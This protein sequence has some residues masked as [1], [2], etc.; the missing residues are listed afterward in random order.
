MQNYMFET[1]RQSE[2]NYPYI[3]SYCSD[4]DNIPMHF[5]EELEIVYILEG[6]VDVLCD[7]NSYIGKPGDLFVFMPGEVHTL[8]GHTNHTTHIF[9]IQPLSRTEKIDFSQV[10]LPDNL[11]STSH[12]AYIPLTE[13][14]MQM[15][16]EDTQKLPGYE[17]AVNQQI[18]AFAMH[19]LRLC[20]LRTI[21]TDEQTRL[22][23]K[24]SFITNA[25]AYIEQHYHEKLD[26]ETAALACGY[27]KYYFAHYF[28]E[29]LHLSF[30]S[31]LTL[32]R[33]EKAIELL[34]ISGKSMTEIAHDCGFGNVR[35][36]NRMF[37]KYYF[38]TPSRYK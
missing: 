4:L 2:N 5:H 26:I 17:F 34:H 29:V 8:N 6:G 11:I 14:V 30:Y 32:F 27:S 31:Y 15:V 36:F 1:I 12:T 10:R 19:L 9:K 25:N 33:L 20:S 3:H 21:P 18:N 37:K 7:E 35:S 38:T 24:L 16:K 28:K 22:N 13:C 23:N